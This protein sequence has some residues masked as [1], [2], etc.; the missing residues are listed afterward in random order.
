[1]QVTQSVYFVHILFQIVSV[2]ERNTFR[3]LEM[4]S[5]HPFHIHILKYT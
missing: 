1:M 5:Y 4:A 3:C 2:P